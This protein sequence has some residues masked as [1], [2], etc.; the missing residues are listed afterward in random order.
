MDYL[1][2][3]SVFVNGLLY[4]ATDSEQDARDFIESRWGFSEVC[5]IYDNQ[6]KEYIFT[7]V[8]I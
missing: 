7:E 3:F 4:R 2:R 8:N 1:K 6:T 5:M